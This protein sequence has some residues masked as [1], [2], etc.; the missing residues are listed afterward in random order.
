L[1]HKN[2]LHPVGQGF[3]LALLKRPALQKI[4][5]SGFIQIYLNLIIKNAMDVML[6]PDYET[7]K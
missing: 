5:L 6:A 3:S 1:E 4:D 7:L 2:R